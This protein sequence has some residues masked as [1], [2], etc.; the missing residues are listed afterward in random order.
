MKKKKII[1]ISAIAIAVLVA[2]VTVLVII[3]SKKEDSYRIIKVYET[4]GEAVVDR[5]NIGEMEAYENMVLESGDRIKVRDGKMTLKLDDD[6]Y[7]YVFENTE[8]ELIAKGTKKDS[9]TTINLIEGCLANEIQNKLS[10]ASSYEINTPNS[11]MSV[12]G[13]VYYVEARIGEDG[14]WYTKVAVFDGTVETG[15]L[16][17]PTESQGNVMVSQGN[18]IIIYG[19]GDAIMDPVTPI[20]FDV[21]P[22]ELMDTMIIINDEHGIA[23]A[24]PKEKQEPDV[25]QEDT[26]Q[27]VKTGPCTI[28]FMY[29]GNEFGRQTIEA[30]ECASKP[31]LNPAPVGDWDFDFST[32][33][34]EDTTIDWR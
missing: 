15:L 4:E 33:I 6:K 30:G 32:E 34:Y 25:L 2:L 29:N 12:R 18:E 28:T 23:V 24:L 9:E 20:D 10:D 1:I 17:G 19:E 16:V 7:I 14:I 3:L 26:L 21:L 22:E 8:F 27:E 5:T 11:T 13:T 31:T